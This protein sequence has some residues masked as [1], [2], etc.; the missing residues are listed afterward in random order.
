MKKNLVF[1]LLT[2]GGVLF[3]IIF[4]FSI[5]Q[6]FSSFSMMSA[7]RIRENSTTSLSTSPI[8]NLSTS[9]NQ[10]VESTLVGD[11]QEIVTILEASSYPTLVVKNG[12]AVKWVIIATAETLNSCNNEIVIPS[13]NLS[14]PLVIGEN[15]I[16]FTPT[17]SGTFDY[18]CWMGMIQSSITVVD[19][20]DDY[21]PS[22]VQ[23]EINNL[24]QTRR[25]H[26]Y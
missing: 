24:S 22:L 16:E 4:V 5:I 11:T 17:E 26:M 25:C 1:S 3:A 7:Y 15:I 6:R 13:L 2:L 21:D 12:V 18:S 23:D 20:L 14:I 10:L 19:D 9:S 8:Q